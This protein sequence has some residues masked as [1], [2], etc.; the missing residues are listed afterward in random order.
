MRRRILIATMLAVAVTAVVLGLPL[1]F[2][3]LKVVGDF[4][5]TDLS[6]RAQQIATLLDEQV[7]TQRPINLRAVQ[8]LVPDEGRLDVRTPNSHH[9]YGADEVKRPL[10]ESVPM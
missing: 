6:N 5:R 8:I 2:S 10:V 3:A 4:A 1:G 7:A 9:T